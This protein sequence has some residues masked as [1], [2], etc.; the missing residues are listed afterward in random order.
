MNYE[1]WARAVLGITAEKNA[2]NRLLEEQVVNVAAGLKEA[3]ER[4][5][6]SAKSQMGDWLAGR[7]PACECPGPARA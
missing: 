2:R 5:E 1:T 4:G 6:R 7:F 3:F